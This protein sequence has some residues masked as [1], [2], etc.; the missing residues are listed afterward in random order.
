[1][2]RILL[3]IVVFFINFSTALAELKY[4]PFPVKAASTQLCG[5]PNVNYP[6]IATL[7]GYAD[8]KEPLFVTHVVK[9]YDLGTSVIGAPLGIEQLQRLEFAV[10]SG[11]P[12][13]NWLVEVFTY[14]DDGSCTLLQTFTALTTVN[15]PN[16]FLGQVN[17]EYV[18]GYQTNIGKPVVYENSFS[19][20]VWH[21]PVLDRDGADVLEKRLGIVYE[22]Y[23]P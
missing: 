7:R 1:M 12:V 6:Y 17:G 3:F 5:E 21:V 2:M 16:P 15:S 20:P 8:S 10:R 9:A 22:E 11:N 13:D 4:V 19:G 23:V 14:H 18:F